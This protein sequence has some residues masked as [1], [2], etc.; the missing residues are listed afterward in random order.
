MRQ[1]QKNIPIERQVASI[2]TDYV[3]SVQRQVTHKKSKKI[4]LFKRLSIFGVLS[5]IIIG[6]FVST[7][8]NSKSTLEEKSYKKSK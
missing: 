4:R 2:N 1:K 8:I 7:L 6:F 5:V 3:R